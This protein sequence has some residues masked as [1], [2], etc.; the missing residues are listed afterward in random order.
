MGSVWAKRHLS[1]NLQPSGV[2][3]LLQ[4]F[5]L[6]CGAGPGPSVKGGGRVGFLEEGPPRFDS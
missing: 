4:S 6:A 1:P 2:L 3:I 5:V